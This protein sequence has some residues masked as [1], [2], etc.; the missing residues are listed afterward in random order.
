VVYLHWGRSFRPVFWRTD[1][2]KSDGKFRLRSGELA[3]M[4]KVV[5]EAVRWLRCG[6]WFEKQWGVG[7]VEGGW[8]TQRDT[9]RDSQSWALSARLW[10]NCLTGPRYVHLVIFSFANRRFGNTGK[11]CRVSRQLQQ[12]SASL[13]H[14]G[15]IITGI[16]LPLTSLAPYCTVNARM[17]TSGFDDQV[18][19]E[20]CL[21]NEI[22][23][24]YF[25]HAVTEC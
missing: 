18:R 7:D 16:T 23:L 12:L 25:L 1:G 24:L 5:W 10:R 20:R 14:H 4:W 17:W 2:A 11:T 22:N 19:A 3:A 8:T 6:R 9:A 15:G 21:M 13:M